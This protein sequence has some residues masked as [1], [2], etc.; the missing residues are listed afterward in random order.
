MKPNYD[1]VLSRDQPAP[2]VLDPSLAEPDR[3][4][5]NCDHHSVCR[6]Y[7][8]WQS[9]LGLRPGGSVLRPSSEDFGKL[10]RFVAG[11][12]PEFREIISGVPDA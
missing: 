6:I 2:A 11:I 3:S 4:C 5:Y 9:M 1:P 10:S 8:A 12:C 7:D